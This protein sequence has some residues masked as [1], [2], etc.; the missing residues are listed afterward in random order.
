MAAEAKDTKIWPV[1][2]QQLSP[3]A[4]LE[5]AACLRAGGLVAFPTETVYGLG[6]DGLNGPAVAAI[7]TAKGRPSDNPLILH[8]A[9]M[10]EVAALTLD[11]P[12]LARRLAERFWPGPLTLVLP[13]SSLVP[14][15]VTAGLA[16]VA[17]RMPSHPVAREL[18]R[19][20][21]VPVAAPSANRSGRPSPTVAEHVREDLWGRIDG[22]VDGGACDFGLESTVVDARGEAAVILRPGG[23]T[24]EMIEAM[25]IP[26]Q[27]F[28]AIG[29]RDAVAVAVQGDERPA[30]TASIQ[31]D[32]VPPSPGMKYVHY[33]PQAPL[34]LLDGNREEQRAA[35][36]RLL[37]TAAAAV[38]GDGAGE[39]TGLLLSEETFRE[40]G[41]RLPGPGDDGPGDKWVVRLTGSREDLTTVAQGLFGAIRSF[42]QTPVSRIVAETY[43]P[44]GIGR[45]VMNRLEKAAG[46]RRWLG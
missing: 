29:R 34:Y 9:A 7:F 41:R 31:E 42:D 14:P 11:F 2:P 40:I 30:P 28:H 13:A 5:A 3:G 17:L 18:I 25:G 22:I 21:G 8:I 15:V 4:L 24:P 39:V 23:V 38:K 35:L 33:A 20:A 36:R 10:D 6:A 16:T 46:G 19:A 44:V 32:F 37:D 1:D 26:V 12:P 45:A 43:P 27:P